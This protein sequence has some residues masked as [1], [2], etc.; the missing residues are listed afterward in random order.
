MWNL[1]RPGIEPVSLALAGRFLSTVP[2]GKTEWDGLDF[3]HS[4][5]TTV[6]RELDH[7]NWVLRAGLLLGADQTNCQAETSRP[8]QQARPMIFFCGPWHT[9]HSPPVQSVT[10]LEVPRF[11]SSDP[12]LHDSGLPYGHSKQCLLGCTTKREQSL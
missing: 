3:H 4:N 5:H 2:P 9:Q 6:S 12:G 11:A 10:P 1:P 7:S 8:R